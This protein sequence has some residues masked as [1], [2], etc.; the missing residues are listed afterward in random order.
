MARPLLDRLETALPCLGWGR[1]YRPRDLPSDLTAGLFVALLL[2]PQS[3]AYAQ[4]AGLPPRV[5]LWAAAVAPLAYALLG[6]SRFLAVGPVALVSLLVGESVARVSRNLGADPMASA[7]VLATL[8]GALL[9]LLGLGRAGFLV[10]FISRPVLQGFTAA[11]A[12]LIAGTQ[13]GH[14]LG[15]DAPR[16]GNLFANLVAVARRWDEIGLP[17]LTL[18]ASAF[19]VLRVMEGPLHALLGRLGVPRSWR[20]PICQTAPLVVTVLGIVVVRLVTLD[21]ELGVRVV[22]EMEAGLPP[23]RLPPVEPRLWWELLPG[24]LAVGTVAF[25]TAVAVG[26]TL[27]GSRREDRLEPD[28]ELVAFGAANLATAVTGG[29]PVGGSVSRSAV[30][31]DVGAATPGASAV[32][33]MALL[34]A[35]MF[36]GPLF[37]SLPRAVL[38]A[39]IFSAALGLLDFAGTRRLWRYSRADAAS[40]W[41]TFASVLLA[42]VEI[43]LAVGAF[44]GLALY[45]W[46]TSEPRV[47][48]EGRLEDGE[49]FRSAERDGV[50]PE[51]SPVLVLRVDRSLYFGNAES[52]EDQ[53]LERIRECGGIECVVVDLKAVN[54]I[55]ASALAVLERMGRNLDSDDVAFALAELK[56]PIRESLERVGFL[57]ELGAGCIYPTVDDAL[58]ALEA[59]LEA[60]Q[61]EG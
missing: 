29:Y 4:L 34:G 57:E 56:E 10:H 22:G 60:R 49:H 54:E 11:A 7:A 51:V 30:T 47:V 50:E 13:L 39:I 9:L 27:A 58:E 15:V 32:T 3:M 45:L 43:G 61:G 19:V 6:T 53:V 42:G 48:I 24:G 59:Q 20:T 55:D 46:R 52:F 38:A 35:V 41:I 5:G 17:A 33:G 2:V 8:A 40:L 26:R 25:V 1:R 28:R 14:L 44:T 12:L 31:H 23:F 37:Q 21:G 18:G 16:S 36:A